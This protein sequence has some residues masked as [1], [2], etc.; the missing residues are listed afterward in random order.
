MIFRFSCVDAKAG[1]RLPSSEMIRLEGVT[2]KRG[3]SEVLR[4]ISLSIPRGS[5]TAI[6]GQSGAG[7][8]TLIGALNGLIPLS[9]GVLTVA[10]VGALDHAG[11][12]REHR[13][14]IA[15]V[16]Q[17]HA[18]IERL[19]A[20][21]NV[22]LGLADERHPLSP[23]P[24]PP[25][26]RR[27]AAE[28]LVEVGLLHH[29]A[30]RI[31][32]LSGGERQRVGI[33]RALVRQPRLLLGDEPFSSLDPILVHNLGESLRRAAAQYGVTVVIVLHQIET[34]LVLADRVIGL[35]GGRVAFD[36][37]AAKFDATIQSLVF[38]SPAR[39]E[40]SRSSNFRTRW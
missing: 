26:M 12:W 14:H 21:D 32:C 20:I 6:V 38:E 39:R 4:E 27:R 11:A 3:D 36:G 8:T 17:D 25:S 24:W 13:R 7:K 23:L 33:A 28:A 19:S 22:L 10:G 16:F 40:I 2:L 35:A 34:A 9:A 18:L 5:V 1:A 37:P 30:T 31:S 29:A 15:T